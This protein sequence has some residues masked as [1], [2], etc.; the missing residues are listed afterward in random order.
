VTTLNAPTGRPPTDQWG[1]SPIFAP[2]RRSPVP[3]GRSRSWPIR[4]ALL[5][6]ATLVGVR[7]AGPL[8]APLLPLALAS[9]PLIG[10]R[11]RRRR[12]ARRYDDE[13]VRLL[14][15]VARSLRSGATLRVAIGETIDV[16]AGPLADDLQRL[17]VELDD[18]V[19]GALEGWAARRPLPSVRLV[20]GGLALGHETGGITSRV[21]DSLADSIRLRLDGR[22]EAVALSTQATASAIVM[23][24][25][26][27]AFLGLGA[28]GDGASA[29]FLLNDPLGRACLAVGLVLDA[30]SL[31][32]M[33][34]VVRSVER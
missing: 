21:V 13:L 6:L 25:V 1:G 4:L 34:R 31:V 15:A 30:A 11:V 10:R 23:S 7:L 16:A 29:R 22:D 5:G 14:R 19:V 12:A 24:C 9:W 8:A 3:D 17:A 20:A 33:L 18:G 27:L 26:P 32:W 2:S 28:L